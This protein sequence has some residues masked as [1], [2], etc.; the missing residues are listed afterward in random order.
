MNRYSRN[1]YLELFYIARH[2]GQYVGISGT[3][4]HNQYLLIG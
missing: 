3:Y 2:A 4:D 1:S